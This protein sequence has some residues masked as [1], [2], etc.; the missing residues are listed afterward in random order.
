[1]SLEAENKATRVEVN[2]AALRPDRE[3]AESGQ[4][5]SIS[6]L[7]GK[8]DFQKQLNNYQNT[9]SDKQKAELGLV[10]Y[11][12]DPQDVSID[13]TK[14]GDFKSFTADT[15]RSAVNASLV[16]LQNNNSDIKA[17]EKVMNRV[18]ERSRGI[19][20]EDFNR[21]AGKD[22]FRVPYRAE[23]GKDGQ[24]HIRKK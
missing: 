14:E 7:A 12:N 19:A 21:T 8:L 5:L 24:I 23:M 1:M 4:L 9:L 11:C 17:A 10:L 16:M 15:W 3:I 20:V 6:L 13:W 2:C 18:N 22:E